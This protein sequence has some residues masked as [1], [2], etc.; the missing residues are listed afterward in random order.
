MTR[1][2]AGPAAGTQPGFTLVEILVALS[3]LAIL[4]AVAMPSY[5]AYVLRTARAEARATMMEA[6]QFM[7]RFYVMNNAYDQT[8]AGAPVALP[9]ALQQSPRQGAPRYQIALVGL[10]PDTYTVQ[11]MPVGASATDGCG[12]LTVTHTGV[13]GATGAAMTVADCWR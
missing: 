3:I 1:R 12:T 6:S 9:A 13:R 8:R 4:A 11:A 10:T 5:S 7:Q 2:N